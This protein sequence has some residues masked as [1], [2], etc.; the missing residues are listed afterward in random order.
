[1]LLKLGITLIAGLQ[2]DLQVVI[3]SLD[4]VSGD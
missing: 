4:S 1:M 3:L 2:L